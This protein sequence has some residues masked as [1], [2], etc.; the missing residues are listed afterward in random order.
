LNSTQL[1][2]LQELPE[3]LAIIGGGV[4]GIEFASIFSRLGVKVTI[5]ELTDRLIPSEEPEISDSLRV[6]LEKKG[7][8]VFLKASA[9]G[10]ER[11]TEGEML[12]QIRKQ[13]GLQQAIPCDKLL[14]CV[15]RKASIQD[16][17]IIELGAAVT[18][19]RVNTD[20]YMRTS[21]PGVYAIGDITASEQ[22]ANVAYLE[23]RT[24]V[25]HI[26]GR[27]GPVDYSAIPHCIYTFPEIASV[28]M[29]EEKAR[30]LFRG[31]KTSRIPLYGNGKAIIEGNTD[32]FIKIVFNEGNG[33]V[34]G[35]SIYGPKATELIS[36]LT[37][38]I[39]KNLKITDI[40]DTVHPHPTLSEAVGEAA[41]AAVGLNLHSL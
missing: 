30:K 33:D 35:V 32:G 11:K 20:E 2:S 23:A 31:V 36:E 18:Q 25:F 26:M 7:V 41:M 39:R 14:V 9:T 8:E 6:S 24:A 17:G 38:A 22:L 27:Y 16:V 5:V 10:L 21:I 37:L 13:D 34:L 4:I 29:S 3:R 15:G 12:V 28:G 19:G 40:V 1:L